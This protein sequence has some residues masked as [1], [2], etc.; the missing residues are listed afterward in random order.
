MMNMFVNA[1]G[2][3]LLNAETYELATPEE[4]R[5]LEQINIAM[6]VFSFLGSSFIIFCYYKFQHL[7][8]F[9]F[10]LVLFVSIS[11]FITSIGNFMGDAGG[12]DDTH[13][14]AS[15]GL[16]VFQAV[17]I[18]YGQ[19]SSVLW[20]A[21]IAF[22]LEMAVLRRSKSFSQEHISQYTYHYI[23][24]CFGAPVIMALLPLITTSYGDTGGWCWIT[25][26]DEA[27]LAWRMFQFYI[28]LW[29]VVIYNC[30]VYFRLYYRLK[31]MNA[32]RPN[33]AAEEN[34]KKIR[35]YP[36]IL[37]ICE[38]WASVN[39]ISETVLGLSD[40]SSNPNNPNLV[41]LITHPFK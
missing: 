29:L 7:H 3:Q 32:E 21:A 2:R 27:G 12:N 11:D 20:S 31:D 26:L 40:R 35:Y 17:L 24:V 41:T 6:S 19:L 10:K 34:M 25:Q 9:P 13:L 8:T 23:S 14:G 37:I 39:A 15:E 36:L 22:T 16:C 4:A 33:R 18:S 1:I 30:Y 38:F 28:P 5:V